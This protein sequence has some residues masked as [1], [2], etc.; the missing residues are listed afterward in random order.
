MTSM[1]ASINGS[2]H[3]QVKV[4]DGSGLDLELTRE[5]AC[6]FLSLVASIV[7]CS[8]PMQ[9]SGDLFLTPSCM[10]TTSAH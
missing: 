6:V 1:E 8:W 5:K 9:E 4:K 10:G 3:G 2:Q 7:S